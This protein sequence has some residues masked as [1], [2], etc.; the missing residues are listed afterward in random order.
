MAL[1]SKASVKLMRIVH[2]KQSNLSILTLPEK[3]LLMKLYCQNGESAT[4]T[5][6][7]YRRKK[8][9]R[10]GEGSMTSSAV[11]RMISK[12]EATSYLADKLV[13]AERGQVLKLLGQFMKK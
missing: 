6:R 4:A 8:G 2:Q 11:K 10:T 3:A 1:Y 9:I 12:F 5:S 7:S 13:V